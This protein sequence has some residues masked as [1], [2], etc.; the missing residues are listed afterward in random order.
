MQSSLPVTTKGEKKKVN[1]RNSISRGS[2]EFNIKQGSKELTVNTP[3]VH[4]LVRQREHEIV[5]KGF[6]TIELPQN[7]DKLEE[8]N[9]DL[10]SVKRLVDKQIAKQANL[11]H[12]LSIRIYHNTQL[13]HVKLRSEEFT[14]LSCMTMRKVKA[15]QHEYMEALLILK[16]LEAFRTHLSY[17]LVNAKTAT[18][19]LAAIQGAHGSPKA[20]TVRKP[21]GR[22]SSYSDE[23]LMKQLKKKEFFPILET[24]PDGTA[25][26]IYSDTA[27]FCN[28]AVALHRTKEI[29]TEGYSMVKLPSGYSKLNNPCA[30]T[31]HAFGLV[32]QARQD[33]VLALK[34]HVVKLQVAVDIAE[35]YFIAG[36][37]RLSAKGMK[38]VKFI[39]QEYLHIL[40]LIEAFKAFEGH[41]QYGFMNLDTIEDDIEEIKSVP[42]SKT[43]CTECD[44][45]LVTQLMDQKFFP[46]LFPLLG[47]GVKIHYSHNPP[48]DRSSPSSPNSNSQDSRP[49]IPN[50]RRLSVGNMAGA[51]KAPGKAGRRP[52]LS[53]IVN[54]P[55]SAR[56]LRAT[57]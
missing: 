52:S 19:D 4:S 12:G 26:F 48:K 8:L 16:G 10:L 24:Q 25:L 3:N 31:K 43:P 56:R 28:H 46:M 5:R 50:A 33:Q 20:G 47:G 13:A 14:F 27:P 15:A 7:V 49:S 41:L 23:S 44:E 34:R 42:S 11:L 51:G 40:R 37:E 39:Q 36:H 21:K 29:A 55:A 32:Q 17:G 53:G 1:F 2:K 57:G 54:R 38:K 6:T 22:R 18:R 9:S 30:E 35:R 45:D